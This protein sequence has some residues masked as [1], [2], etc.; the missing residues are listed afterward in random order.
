M[1]YRYNAFG[2]DEQDNTL[3][4]KKET[5]GD[6]PA[7]EEEVKEMDQPRYNAF[8]VDE[9]DNTFV[10]ENETSKNILDRAKEVEARA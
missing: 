6:P 7:D 5:S 3:A 9:H 1:T 2:V 4:V 10:V 8:L